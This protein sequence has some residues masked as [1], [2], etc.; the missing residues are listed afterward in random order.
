MIA[1]NSVLCVCIE[2]KFN[3]CLNGNLSHVQEIHH[4]VYSLKGGEQIHDTF[5]FMLSSHPFPTER[6]EQ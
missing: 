2:W 1:W 3:E 5:V 4:F 6:S